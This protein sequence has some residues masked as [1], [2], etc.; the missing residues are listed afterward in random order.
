MFM[1][2]IKNEIR[3]DGTQRNSNIELFRILTMLLIIAHHY[4]VN[5]GLLGTNGPMRMYPLSLRTVLLYLFGA[6]G[7]T[8]INCFVLISG[9]FMCTTRITT[10]KFAKLLLEVEFYKII[11][12]L[13]FVA[14]GYEG[15]SVIGFVKAILP[16]TSVAQGFTG[17]YLLFYLLIPFLNIT[18]QNTSQKQHLKLILMLSFIYIILGTL[19]GANVQ[20][21]YVTWFV[22]LYFIA[23][24][25]RLYPNTAF[26]NTKLWTIL[27]AGAV[28]VSAASVVSFH[29]IG[30]RLGGISAYS[31]MTDSNKILAFAT[32]FCSFMFFKNVHIRQSKLINTVA[33]SSFG[34]LLIHSGSNAMRRFLWVDLLRVKEMYNSQFILFHAVGSVLGIYVVCTAIDY[35][36]IQFVEKPLFRLWDRHWGKIARKYSLMENRI[37]SK[38]GLEINGK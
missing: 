10:K 13:V 6:W 27:A 21:N 19:L 38:L 34:V 17:C 7:K 9:Y 26:E 18:V 35:L 8:G 14:A 15:F 2:K 32:G 30:I 4:V 23:A 12:Y 11:I 31:F 37:C 22:V 20:M 36:R 25:V 28:G 29:Y 3:G 1:P 16:V 24:Y 5:S 33:A